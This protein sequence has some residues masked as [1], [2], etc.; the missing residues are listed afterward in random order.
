MSRTSLP[1]LLAA[2][3]LAACAE[4]PA[5]EAEERTVQALVV[6]ER[7]EGDGEPVTSVSAKFMRSLPSDRAATEAL[8][9]A[10]LALPALS[11]CVAEQQLARAD[12]A[13][14]A[15]IETGVE[16]TSATQ[17]RITLNQADRQGLLTRLNRD[18]TSSK[19]NVSYLLAATPGWNTASRSGPPNWTGP[20]PT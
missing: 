19:G 5:P 14:D 11:E 1:L 4:V 7:T 8:V 17:F 6:V 20:T 9:G 18:G 13:S 16:I 2:L 3:G 15:T 10:R 12:A